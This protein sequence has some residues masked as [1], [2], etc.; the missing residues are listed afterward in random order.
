MDAP[1][2]HPAHPALIRSRRQVFKWLAEHKPKL[3]RTL[4]GVWIANEENSKVLGIGVSAQGQRCAGGGVC[5][6]AEQALFCCLGRTGKLTLHSQGVIG[7]SLGHWGAIRFDWGRLLDLRAVKE[8]QLAEGGR[9]QE[10]SRH[11]VCE[12]Q[13]GVKRTQ[14]STSHPFPFLHVCAIVFLRPTC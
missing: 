14:G 2:L 8:G 3:K 7:A 4:V 9:W 5:I 12:G 10:L 13:A 11:I 1:H 6:P